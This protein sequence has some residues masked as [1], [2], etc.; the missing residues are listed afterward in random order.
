MIPELVDDTYVFLVDTNQYAGSFERE[1]CAYI[2]GRW[3]EC[4]VGRD[5]A[6]FV[7][8]RDAEELAAIEPYIVGKTDDHGCHRPVTVYPTR[9]LTS[10]GTHTAVPSGNPTAIDREAPAYFTVA[11]FSHK[12]FGPEELTVLD[13]RAYQFIEDVKAGILDDYLRSAATMRRQCET[14]EIQRTSF[15]TLTTNLE[16]TWETT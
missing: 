1:M 3:G 11:I 13:R 16:V 2:T 10:K 4:G 8:A 15:G 6:R 5:L 14:L 7:L 12:V 9:G